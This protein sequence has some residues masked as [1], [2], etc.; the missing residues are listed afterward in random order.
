MMIKFLAHGTGSARR[1]RTISLA[2]DS[3]RRT[4]S[5]TRIKKEPEEVKVLRGNPHQVAAVA[6]T[7]EFEHKYTSGVMAWAPEDARAR[8][9][10]VR[11]WTSSRRPPGRD[12][13]RTATP[14]RRCSTAKREE[15]CT[16]MYWRR[17][18]DLATGKSLN[19]A[20][21]AGRRR[22]T[23]YGTGRTMSTA[24]AARTIP[25]GR[26]RAPG[27]S[28]LHHSRPGPGGV[29]GRKDPRRLITDYL[30]Q[31]IET[32]AVS[33]APLMVSA[34]RKRTLR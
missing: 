27:A 2:R 16:Y 6:D 10:S 18:C 34:L 5:K 28:S 25:N 33:I 30:S 3:P 32:G 31:R 9:R 15:G 29:G 11:W 13:N 7:L 19:I 14:G 23:R 22:L 8:R 17:V 12:W 24:G 21:R 4:R 26:G 1:R 20:A